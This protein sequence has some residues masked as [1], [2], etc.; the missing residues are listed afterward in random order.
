MW[1]R[2]RQARKKG[3]KGEDGIEGENENKVCI[4]KLLKW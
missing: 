3:K 2:K 4:V 1:L